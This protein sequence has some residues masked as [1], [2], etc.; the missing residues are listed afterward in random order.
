MRALLGALLVPQAI[1]AQVPDTRIA[2]DADRYLTARSEMGNFSGA[3][4]IAKGD[5]VIFRKGYG[6]ADLEKRIPFTPGTQHAIASI[7][8]MFTAMAALKLR[9]EG[10]LE[11]GD[12]V[13]KYYIDCPQAWR[14]VTIDHLIH[15]T[16]GIPDYEAEL[17]LGSDKYIDFMRQPGSRTR[18]LTQMATKPLEFTPGEKFNYSNTGYI[19]LAQ[20]VGQAAGIPFAEYVRNEIFIPAGMTRTGALGTSDPTSLAKGYTYESL[21]WGVTASAGK[22]TTATGSGAN[23]GASAGEACT[24]TCTRT[25]STAGTETGAMNR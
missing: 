20:A 16:S 18:I 15:H 3:V 23:G 19:L 2:R 12:S 9:D 17:E 24:C 10:K 25:T 5:R 1:T 14:P 13:C 22:A 7:S 8:K 11:L 6:F 21:G 4:L